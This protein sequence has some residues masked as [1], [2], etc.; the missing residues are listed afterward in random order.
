MKLFVVRHG[1]TVWNKEG[2]MQGSGDSPLT[3]LGILEASKLGKALK[4]TEIDKIYTSPLGR[5]LQTTEYIKGDRDIPVSVIDEL[6]EINF[7]KIE[8]KELRVVEEKYG[9]MIYN[10]WNNPL[11]YKNDSG[12]SF[13]DLYG[14]VK[15][16]MDQIV[17]NRGKEK[18]VLVI[19]HGVVISALISWINGGSVQDTWKTPVVKNTSVS[20][21]EYNGEGRLEIIKKNDISHLG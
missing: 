17:A 7:G 21:L 11:K 6:Q 19:T 18:N 14:R 10:F 5:T 2:R 3:D 16:A 15:V 12:E 9:E 13:S 4:N 8:G 20:I 1:Q